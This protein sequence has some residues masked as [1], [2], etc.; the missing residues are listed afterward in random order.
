MQPAPTAEGSAALR[1]GCAR[2]ATASPRVGGMRRMPAVT[3]PTLPMFVVALT[4]LF[5]TLLFTQQQTSSR[6]PSTVVTGRV[7]DA[8]GEPLIGANV[9]VKGTVLGGATRRDG[10]FE[11]RQ[12]PRGVRVLRVSMIGYETLERS[13]TIDSARMALAD[14]V[15]RETAV[16][17]GEVVV[18]A[19]RRPQSLED[20]PVSMAVFDAKDVERRTL[21]SL[22]QA[23][24]QV[25]G[26]NM[27]ESQ[28]NIRGSS[29]YSR[30][31]GSRVLLLLDGVPLLT[32]DAGEIKYDVVPMYMVDRIEVL[33][34]AGSALYGS[35]ALGG[36]VNV[37]TK[38][39]AARMLGARVY[40]GF[41]DAPQYDRWKWW[42][43]SPRF[44]NGIDAHVGGGRQFG[45][46]GE[47][48][49]YIASAGVRNNQGY[50]QGDASF[51]WNGF[52]KGEWKL[53]PERALAAT[54]NYASELRSNWI[55][56]RSLDDAL[57]PPA[58]T[59]LGERTHST[60]LQAT[61]SWRDTPS[62]S[63]AWSARGTWFRTSYDLESDTSDFSLRPN[64]RV[65]S[66]THT[67]LMGLQGAWAPSQRL[68]VTHGVDASVG[69]VDARTFGR[70]T[71]TTSAVYGQAD[72]GVIEGLNLS[73]GARADYTW[74]D[75]AKA[76][77][78]LSPRLGAAWT[79]VRGTTLRAS[80]GMGF[81]APSIAERFT[82]AS[83]AGIRTKPNPSLLSERSVSYELGVRQELPLPAVVDGA[84]FLADYNN[85][86]EPVIDSDGMVIFRNVTRAR[87]TGGELGIMTQLIDRMLTLSAGWTYMDPRDLVLA[88][89]LKYRPRHLFTASA[90]FEYGMFALGADYR[91]S[92]RVEVI[93]EELRL[94]I[95]D[96]DARVPI[97]VVDARVSAD[98]RGAGLPLTATLQV[99]NLLQYN[100]V[101]IVGNIAPIRHFMLTLDARL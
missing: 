43:S 7:V 59:D 96:G 64:D 34:G 97:H 72:W 40:T 62:A 25:P 86:V 90:V 92:S 41:Y 3:R 9:L 95:R 21:V 42:G 58:G 8:A 88:R 20:V 67:V 44:M 11:L 35:S 48:V 17:T 36:V 33:K 19:G 2:W 77:G 82:T 26:V 6:A 16:H 93:D 83:G 69:F 71:G 12:V 14:L 89:A 94:V 39:P 46:E 15:L 29:G 4:L 5:P 80:A 60:K 54:V 57:V 13:V 1:A 45:T 22:D 50:R 74:V 10:T 70:R 32:G 38:R 51:R 84:V 56:W 28:I 85:L 100:Y 37:I 63:Y 65:Q 66:T 81:R 68:V 79:I 101:E 47:E 87:I 30:A 49:S 55:Y 23:L 52:A 18:T 75:S 78:R 99:N 91:G 53:G 31:L 73:A 27:T 24:R 61:V 76:D 98:L